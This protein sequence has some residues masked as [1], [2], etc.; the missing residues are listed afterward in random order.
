MTELKLKAIIIKVLGITESEFSEDKDFIND[1]AADSLDLTE[2]IMETESIFGI[3]IPDEDVDKLRTY[4][5]VLGYIKS[6]VA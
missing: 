4:N 2:L 5:D 1:Y 3:I 6:K